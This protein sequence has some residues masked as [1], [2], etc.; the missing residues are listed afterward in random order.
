MHAITALLTGK[1][2]ALGQGVSTGIAKLPAGGPL[3]LA[4][5]GLRGDEQGDRQYHGGPEKALHHYAL[6]HYPHWRGRF[7]AAAPLQGPG[8]F[9]ENIATLGMTER[10][11]HVGDVYRVGTALVQVSQGRQPCWKLN[12]RFG[13]PDAAR[14][15]QDS[16]LTGWYYRVLRPGWIA[17][18]DLLELQERPLPDWPLARLIAA[19]FLL[20][21]PAGEGAAAGRPG[22]A[23]WRAE[24]QAAAAL[25]PL[26]ENWRANFRLRL[27]RGGVEDWGRRLDTPNTF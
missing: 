19:L 16:G 5:D 27:E 10:D 13:Q 9:G 20:P 22:A 12:L 8:A 14:A 4:A 18:A 23:A 7:G 2:V 6:E 21:R 25:A 17:P 11:V 15:V 24:W 26:A 3:W 1:A